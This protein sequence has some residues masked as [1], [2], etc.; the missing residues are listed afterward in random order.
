MSSWARV[1]DEARRRHD[2]AAAALAAASNT[3]SEPPRESWRLLHAA[4]RTADIE[5]SAV[6]HDDPRLG[7][8]L[9]QFSRDWGCILY[10]T[11]VGPQRM[12]LNVAHEFGHVWLDGTTGVLH[13]TT[14]DIDP[15]AA[16]EPGL[17]GA[18]RVTG[19]GPAELRE[20]RANV[21]A[22]EFLLPA[23]EAVRLHEA[24]FSADE[25]ARG[26]GLPRP[27]V[28]QQLSAG[29]LSPDDETGSH[30]AAGDE[31][32]ALDRSQLC[33]ATAARGPLLVEAGPGTGKTRT[34]IA[35]IVHLL[36]H[37]QPP[38]RI[39][40]LTFS[41]RA[42]EEMRERIARVAP[43]AAERIWIGT[44]HAFAL[45]LLRRFADE[46]K[47][48]P[49]FHVIDPADALALLED[50]L[51][52]LK[53]I[54][55]RN[56]R[57]PGWP[58]REVLTAISH[59]QDEDI[60][61]LQYAAMAG[62][63]LAALDPHDESAEGEKRRRSANRT[64][65][66]AR[67]YTW[68]DRALRERGV[69]DF[70]G[71]LCRAIALLRDNASLRRRVQR[72]YAHV[73][74]DEYQD[75]NRASSLLLQQIAGRGRGLWVVGDPRQA[76]YRFR[77]ASPANIAQFDR[78]FPGARTLAL[79]RNYRSRPAVLDAVNQFASQ[80]PPSSSGAFAPWD[81][82]RSAGGHGVQRVDAP[83]RSSEAAAL[84]D[85]IEELRSAGIA[86]AD[87]AVLCR[88]HA[89]L[90][91]AGETLERAGIPT[92]YLGNLF[93]RPECRDLLAVLELLAGSS[94]ALLRVAS[95]A[96]YSV[97][98]KDI[99]A[100]LRSASESGARFP[101]ALALADELA[102]LSPAARL[103]LHR[104][105][106]H[107]RGLDALAPDD[108]LAEY[109]LVRSGYLRDAHRSPSANP[110]QRLALYQLLQFAREERRA[111]P[112]LTSAGFLH[113]VRRLA[114]YGD[115]RNLRQLP[116]SA[117][118]LDAV[119]LLTVHAAK[120]LE[121][122]AVHLPGLGA[123]QFPLS[124][125]GGSVALPPGALGGYTDAKTIHDAE[126]ECLFFVALSRAR[127][128]VTLL[129]PARLVKQ[130]SNPSP[131][132]A[133]VEPA[134][135]S[136]V[137]AG[138]VELT[139]PT[140]R[141]ESSV[142]RQFTA[143]ELDLYRRCPRR[144]LY[145]E[146][147][148]LD[149][150]VDETAYYRFRAVAHGIVRPILTGQITDATTARQKLMEL[151]EATGPCID[152]NAELLFEE[153]STIVGRALEH[154]QGA[155][156]RDRRTFTLALPHGTVSLRPD[157]IEDRSGSRRLQR[158]RFGRIASDEQDEPIYALYD[159]AA[160]L[161]SKRTGMPVEV[162]TLALGGEGAVARPVLSTSRKFANRLTLYDDAIQSIRS[163][164]FPAEPEE[165]RFCPSCPHYHICGAGEGAL[166]D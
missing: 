59:A 123:G 92:F 86:Y 8:A 45:D 67:V 135:T 95:L 70:G 141:Y 62:E 109:L 154:A 99:R 71:L 3:A 162:E 79:R 110:R 114:L 128:A 69:I 165:P 106:E 150:D 73:L 149:R 60:D 20:R 143:K 101:E 17:S 104:L 130:N 107:L 89:V 121:F 6:P 159:L 94:R 33:A 83:D 119:R 13:C 65:E 66:V 40:A 78:D 147:F 49:H 80:M 122:A 2:T 31:A 157:N 34:L 152:V 42:A 5:L 37:E 39:L 16:T 96:E 1:R 18:E 100:L 142:R 68:Y 10:D 153:A 4:A 124:R 38:E 163:G 136:H 91:R 126:E 53:L 35:R 139:V 11:S 32:L 58:L 74:V 137:T 47:L 57:A 117:T 140:E 166:P 125:R 50:G 113:R 30:D 87:Q 12:A 41:N 131:F 72:E 81:A 90:A 82:D 25:I 134:I 26:V 43:D 132:L 46:A 24:G 63:T 56:A 118:S 138:T 23:A 164:A 15:E 36:A 160:R 158:L 28:M 115:E 48:D 64:A 97:P 52:E 51:S 112:A 120:G 102:T 144:Y 161:E 55:F 129:R 151:W 155:T 88:T 116:E 29:L 22:R 156:P 27:L 19:Y 98:L 44:F 103:G 85:R 61:P 75:V 7:G 145:E 127:E 146:L 108:A 133:R 76:I 77:G 105:R 93:E 111:R 9:A 148:G 84:A 14:E 54:E 21:F